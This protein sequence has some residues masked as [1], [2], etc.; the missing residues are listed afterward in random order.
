MSNSLEKISDCNNMCINRD[1][2][3]KEL[4]TDST[5]PRICQEM[6]NIC[7]DGC[8]RISSNGLEIVKNCGVYY[9]CKEDSND[10]QDCLTSQS[11]NIITCCKQGCV[12]DN[13]PDCNSGLLC[14]SFLDVLK[15]RVTPR[16]II[17]ELSSSSYSHKKDMILKFWVILSIFITVSL[18]IL[19]I[20]RFVILK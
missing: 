18:I 9:G 12:S 6:L 11:E 10:Y 14:P 16:K 13:S 1:Q 7:L 17:T 5:C 8:N 19:G 20:V 15:T 2:R 4:C 3:C